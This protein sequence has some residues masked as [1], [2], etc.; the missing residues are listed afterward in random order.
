MKKFILTI[1]L[2]I[3][4]LSRLN[5]QWEILN[6]GFKGTI[7]TIDFVNENTGWLA[8]YI[9]NLLKTTDGGENWI[10]IEIEESWNINQIDFINDSTGWGVGWAN[11]SNNCIVLKTE[12]GGYNWAVKRSIPDS[13]LNLICVVDENNIYTAGDRIYK[14]TDG[15]NK[16]TDISPNIQGENYNSISF[17]NPEIGVV[18]GNNN[19]T[20][21][22]GMILITT[23]GGSNWEQKIVNEFS[24]I[25]DLQFINDTAGYFIAKSGLNDLLCKTD[26]MFESWIIQLS[27]RINSYHFLDSSVAYAV[28]RDSLI[29]KSTDGGVSWSGIQTINP[30]LGG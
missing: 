21:Y 20:G 3:L 10:S 19:E 16:W 18:V 13:Y 11:Y 24:E 22:K 6:E 1:A 29:M 23:N 2:L 17:R 4:M 8:G 28:V 25:T 5:A 27:N 12:D 9:G 30:S 7:Y 14:T 15:G 26:N